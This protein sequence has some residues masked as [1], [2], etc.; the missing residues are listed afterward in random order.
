MSR[1][2]QDIRRLFG[3]GSSLALDAEFKPKHDPKNGQFT[4][5]SGGSGSSAIPKP[6]TS[7]V[8]RVQQATRGYSGTLSPAA[9]AA[10]EK[11]TK[12]EAAKAEKK[13][14][15]KKLKEASKPKKTATPKPEKAPA[16]KKSSSTT[17]EKTVKS[18]EGKQQTEGKAMA[19]VSKLDS[20]K[21]D[22]IAVVM[23]IDP[24]DEHYISKIKAAKSP[25]GVAKVL[26]QARQELGRFFAT[27]KALS[28]IG[29]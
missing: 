16:K 25:K 26:E 2:Q 15:A 17:S 27:E 29:V 12:Q 28:R 4:S 21:N 10:A 6:K 22:A 8:K 1:I 20:S 9:L 7:R 19:K 5:G 18:K 3:S 14:E 11:V 23:G 13:S 24:S